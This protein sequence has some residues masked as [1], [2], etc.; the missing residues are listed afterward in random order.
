MCQVHC[1]IGDE[2]RCKHRATS[3]CNFRHYY[4]VVHKRI[5]LFAVW[6][7][8]TVEARI[9]PIVVTL[10]HRHQRIADREIVKVQFHTANQFSGTASLAHHHLS[11]IGII[12]NAFRALSIAWIDGC[13]A[14]SAYNK[15]D[16]AAVLGQQHVARESRLR[17]VANMSKSHHIID[18]FIL[19]QCTGKRIAHGN[20]ITINYPFAIGIGNHA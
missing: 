18:T 2:V 19:F 13:M 6:G 4:S 10:I 8:E 20:C 7:K 17:G 9:H 15:V 16:I 12:E 5:H 1:Q 14:V 3:N 11:A